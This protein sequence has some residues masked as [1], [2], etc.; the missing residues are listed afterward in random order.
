MKKPI[1]ISLAILA[2]LAPAVASA[3][4]KAKSFTVLLA[5]GAEAN[6]IRIWL[7]PDGREYVIDSLVQLEVGGDLCSHPEGKPNELVCAAARIGGFEVNAGAGDDRVVVSR[8]VAIPVTIRGGPGDDVLVGGSGDD[9]LIG[10]AG[11]DRLY[12][13]RGADALY[14]GPGNDLLFG[15]PGSDLL[16]GGPGSDLLRGGP[17]QN[18]LRQS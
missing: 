10:G 5:G 2:V 18:I 3:M 16:R 15:G 8:N 7:G 1:L 11:D 14:G 17:G 9:K 12:G 4:P 6:T 13:R